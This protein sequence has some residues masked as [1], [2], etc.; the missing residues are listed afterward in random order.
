MRSLWVP[1]ICVAA[2]G[3]RIFRCV[4]SAAHFFIFR[5]NKMFNNIGGKIK[6]LAELITAFGIIAS[7]VG[8]LVIMGL[9]SD[10]EMLV[11]GL[12]IGVLGVLI[13]WIF[14][15]VLYGFGQ[16]IESNEEEVLLLKRL[17]HKNDTVETNMPKQN[18]EQ[19]HK[20]QF[21]SNMANLENLNA[22]RVSGIITEE[23]YQ[24]AVTVHS[25]MST[26][27][28]LCP[29]CKSSVQA[30]SSFCGICGHKFS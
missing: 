25:Q 24:A 28:V 9:G 21:D 6:Q 30:G 11:P 1:R 10:G 22:L 12:L 29:S 2:I 18:T 5:R 7:I 14:S 13:S 3:V 19:V 26:G 15:F 20:S 8:G 4:A 27:T 23:E 16:L 17:S